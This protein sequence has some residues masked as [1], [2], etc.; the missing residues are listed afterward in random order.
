MK[1][2]NLKMMM[3]T[4]LAAFLTV[5]CAQSK[6]N[7]SQAKPASTY[8]TNYFSWDG[9]T[10]RSLQYNQQVNPGYCNSNPFTQTATG[11][12]DA[13][14]GQIVSQ[15]YC[16]PVTGTVGISCVGLYD[17]NNGGTFV[18]VRC[19]GADCAG[20]TLYDVNTRQPVQCR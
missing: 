14:S 6:S 16:A 7:D 5:G 4:V 3:L 11:C 2:L 10:C 19:S 8:N 20:Y 15:A 9:V 1:T 13:I 17:W 12:M 18:R